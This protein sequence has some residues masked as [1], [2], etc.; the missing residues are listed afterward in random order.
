MG[1]VAGDGMVPEAYVM[2]ADEVRM[3]R[4]LRPH[5]NSD[6]NLQ[7]RLVRQRGHSTLLDDYYLEICGVRPTDRALPEPKKKPAP[8]QGSL[9]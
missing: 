2:K 5:E 6:L 8:A 9:F 7:V 1:S 4:Q 3:T